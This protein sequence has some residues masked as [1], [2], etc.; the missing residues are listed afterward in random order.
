MKSG[1]E[2]SRFPVYQ[3]K[4]QSCA[5]VAGAGLPRE[6]RGRGAGQQGGP[7]KVGRHLVG[8]VTGQSLSSY[9]MSAKWAA[10]GREIALVPPLD[11]LA[12]AKRDLLALNSC[13]YRA[14]LKGVGQVW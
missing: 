2:K 9:V 4:I 10:I 7:G 1:V 6:W 12:L 5:A 14:R 13:L 3:I 8:S 11:S